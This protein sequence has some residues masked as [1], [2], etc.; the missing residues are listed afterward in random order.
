MYEYAPRFQKK[1]EKVLCWFFALIGCLLVLLP[2]FLGELL[3]F[4]A[5]VQALGVGCIAVMILIFSLVVSKHYIY[6][7][8]EADEDGNVD[9]LITECAGP[10]RTVV[11]RVSVTSVL[12]VIP[13]TEETRKTYASR[14]SGMQQYN[15][16][17]VLFGEDQRYL[18]I[19]EGGESFLVRICA[20]DDLLSHLNR[21]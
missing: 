11:C 8:T 20:T 15:Y 1:K 21:H 3:P 16:T 5:A 10:R 14:A 2:S 17:G 9:L 19:E 6:S 7:I 12:E 13:V 4:P 18:K